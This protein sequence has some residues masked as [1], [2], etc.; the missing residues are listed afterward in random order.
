MAGQ[1]V[2][3]PNM[4]LTQFG[5]KVMIYSW[6]FSLSWFYV[7]TSE[8]CVWTAIVRSNV[9]FTRRANVPVIGDTASG[10]SSAPTW[11]RVDLHLGIGGWGWWLEHPIRR[12]ITNR[13][14]LQ[15]IE[16]PIEK[17]PIW[18][19]THLSVSN[20]QES[21]TFHFPKRIMFQWR[22]ILGGDNVK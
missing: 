7:V 4:S 2:N 10:V 12:V 5:E 6:F 1:E 22:N 20:L 18:P 8:A 14:Y 15:N 3:S 21:Q 19:T 17:P 11:F 9:F 13:G 16:K